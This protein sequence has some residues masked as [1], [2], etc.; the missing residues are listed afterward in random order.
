MQRLPQFVK[1]AILDSGI[2]HYIVVLRDP[3][4]GRCTLWDFGPKGGDVHIDLPGCP[5]QQ[6]QQQT[7]QKGH[8]AHGEEESPGIVSDFMTPHQYD[9]HKSYS[10][11]AS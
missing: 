4:D 1:D 8:S 6:L 5:L 10:D 2:C 3:L 7:D 9:Y 11:D